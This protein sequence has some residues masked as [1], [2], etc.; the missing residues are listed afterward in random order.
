MPASR[1]QDPRLLSRRHHQRICTNPLNDS[2]SSFFVERIQLLD[3]APNAVIRL[4]CV[5]QLVVAFVHKSVI[6]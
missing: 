2:V 4:I 5:D 6:L 1:R 3:V